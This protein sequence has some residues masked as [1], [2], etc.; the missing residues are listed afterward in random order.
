MTDEVKNTFCAHENYPE[1]SSMK[2][3]V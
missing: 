2:I 1:Y 3:Y